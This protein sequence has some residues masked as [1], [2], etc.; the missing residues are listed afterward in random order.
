MTSSWIVAAVLIGAII[1]AASSGYLADRISRKWTKFVAGCV[2]VIGAILEATAQS[3]LWLIIARLILGL[4]VG[5]ASF[6]APEYI[7]EQTPPK[8]RGGTVSYNQLMVTLGI[9]LAYVAG[10]GLAG[11]GGSNWRWMLGI[12]AVPRRR[13]RDQHDLRPAY[14]AMAG[15]QGPRGRRAGGPGAYSAPAR[16]AGRTGL[17]PGR[18]GERAQDIAARPDW[19]P[20]PAD[21]GDRPGAGPHPAVRGDQHGD[22]LHIHDLEVHRLEHQ[23]VGAAGGVRGADGLRAHHRGDLV[24]GLARPPGHLD[25][26]TVVATCA[27]V[28]LG[29]YFLFPGFAA[30]NAWFGLLCVI[31][32]I[33]GF[34]FSLGPVFWLMISEIFPLAH[35]SKAMAVCTVFNWA[36]NFIVSYFFL[37]EIGLIG[38]AATF[39]IYA[40]IGVLETGFIW[41]RVPETKGKSLEQI[42]DDVRGR[43][44]QAA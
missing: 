34:A 38:K 9:L 23:L 20:D 11:V 27:L 1:G 16:G 44:E 26:G 15:Q 25:H 10:F 29:F 22:L 24:H 2:F 13:A 3:S 18:G 30:A 42:E 31:V 8:I 14:P 6:V 19:R 17:H 28:A 41:L 39:W 35:R 4:G 43:P 12:G 37:Q 32:Y 21:A 5:T 36:A 33:A 7:A 40:F